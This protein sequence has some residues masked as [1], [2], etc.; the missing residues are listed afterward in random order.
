MLAS[1]D[2]LFDS[3]LADLGQVGFSWHFS[4]GTLA[5][6]GSPAP[7]LG[8]LPDDV[9]NT[10]NA[11]KALINPQDLPNLMTAL[12]DHVARL[13]GAG[14]RRISEPFRLR[15]RD[16]TQRTMRLEGRIALNEHDTSPVLSGIIREDMLATAALT[17][18][19]PSRAAIAEVME[20]LLLGR[21]TAIR[22]RG[23]FMALGLDRVGLLNASYGAS[24]VD[25]VLVEVEHRLSV[26]LEGRAQVSRIAGDIYGLLFE[27]MP[28]S[29]ADALAAALLQLFTS[30]PVL[31]MHGPVMIG[32]SIGGAALVST[33]EKGSDIVAR[34]EAALG[35][36]KAKGRGCFVVSSPLAEK[37][38]RARKLLAG[39]QAV[40]R[41]LEE[42]R[43]RMA[44]QPVIDLEQGDKI[45][46]YE[47]LIRM[48]DE[49]GKLVPAD[50]FIPSLEELGM[51]RLLDIYSLHT[52]VRELEHF[53]QIN[54]S[55]NVSNL[56]LMDTAWLRAAVGLLAGKPQVGKRLI[57]EITE[58]SAMDDIESA[59]RIINTL[60]ELGCRIALDDFGAGQTSFRQLKMLA[61]DVVK[62]D[63]EYIRKI[64]QV[65][66]RLFVKSLVE[67]ADGMN[68]KTVAEGVETEAEGELLRRN[69]LDYLQGYAYGYPSIERTWLPK[70]H[71]RRIQ[72]AV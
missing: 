30:T 17:S 60:K 2:T 24:F 46:F 18:A 16:G 66:N 68:L 40:Y 23:Y 28:H 61:I 38:E 26:F 44:F 7:V 20:R 49:S 21:S 11:F 29:Q 57:V 67:L 4:N 12:Q 54:L 3:T 45:G 42:G 65:E 19:A 39:G 37:R 36:A 1:E 52:A 14:T 55:V 13:E 31:T 62:I 5:W 56:S 33:E 63:K 72:Q 71:E 6:R 64:D 8:L 51:M 10:A 22:N 25:T 34:A 48:V 41:A 27:D 35:T 53:P 32:L 70:N 59:A 47:C 9:P 15:L 43:M 69:G 58:S 50:S